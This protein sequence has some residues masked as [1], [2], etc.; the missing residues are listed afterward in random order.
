MGL[1]YSKMKIFHYPEKL[2]SLPLTNKEILPPLHIRI[3]PT[4]ACNHRCRYCAYLDENLQLGKDMEIRDSIPRDKMMEII[5]DLDTMGVKAITFSGGGEPF[6]YPHFLETIRKLTK[7]KVKF[8]SL[9]NGARITGE[10]AELFAQHAT[11]LRISIDGWDD[12]SY[13][14]Y[15]GIRVG[16]FTKVLDNMKRFKAMKG[17][18]YLGISFIVDRQ[19]ADH[20]YEFVLKMKEI[21]VDSVKISPCIVSNDG[22][23]NNAYHQP[24]YQLIKDQAQRAVEELQ[25]PNF[26]IFDSYHL[27]DEKFDR[28]YSWCPYI[29]IHPVIGADLNIYSCHDKAYNLDSGIIGSIRDQRFK[30]YWFSDKRNFF[31]INPSLHCGHHCCVNDRNKAVLEYLGADPVHL[32]FV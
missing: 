14:Q 13:A 7:T 11:W 9:S 23:E 26:E 15:R 25:A 17:P 5:D 28:P 1:L 29:Q 12:E 6:V 4:N 16:E 2:A 8:A 10:I 22:K 32:D 19:N 18:C 27:L 20:V 30:D 3:K 24:V 31:K 21:G